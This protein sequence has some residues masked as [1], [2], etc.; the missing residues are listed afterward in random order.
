MADKTNKTLDVRIS[1]A[2]NANGN[3]D[4][5]ALVSLLDEAFDEHAELEEIIKIETPRI[6][7]LT[8]ADPDKST[9]AVSSAKLKIQRLNLAIPLLRQRVDAIERG[10]KLSSGMRSPGGGDRDHASK[11]GRHPRRGRLHES[12]R[13]RSSKHF[14]SHRL[15][16]Q[17][18][19]I[20]GT[21]TNP[22]HQAL[23]GRQ[24]PRNPVVLRFLLNHPG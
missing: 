5:D 23:S 12:L 15:R 11:Q 19:E 21:L 2:L 8:N 3:A 4:R 17:N 16:S 10:A 9:T 14:L 13:Q 7:D 22:R 20:R 1:A 18:P 24:K 6:L